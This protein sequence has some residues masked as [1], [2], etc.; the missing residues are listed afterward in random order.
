MERAGSEFGLSNA[1][2]SRVRQ[3]LYELRGW[4]IHLAAINGQAAVITF[5]RSNGHINV[6][7]G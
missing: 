1:L 7:S 6:S 2:L 5:P 4:S 3:G